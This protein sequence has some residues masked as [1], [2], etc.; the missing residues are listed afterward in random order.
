MTNS[1]PY[2]VPSSTDYPRRPRKSWSG[3]A[4]GIYL[5]LGFILFLGIFVVGPWAGREPF[6]GPVQLADIIIL[7]GGGGVGFVATLTWMLVTCVATARGRLPSGALLLLLPAG[8]ACFAYFSCVDM[9]VSDR[10]AYD[11]ILQ[12]QR[13]PQQMR[14]K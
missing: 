5:T 6:Y 7:I 3:C 11:K 10:M 1:D 8:I 9:Y 12:R 4:I 14:L 2:R 13:N